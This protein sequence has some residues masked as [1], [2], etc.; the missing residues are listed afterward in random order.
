M[1]VTI[2]LLHEKFPEPEFTALQREVFAG[3]EAESSALADV[4]AAEQ[5]QAQSLTGGEPL[6]HAPIVR[7]GAYAEGDLVGW[8]YGW[9]ER[10]N[11]FY[12]ANSGV[13]AGYRRRGV[14]SAL[15]G[16]VI[17][18]A[19]GNGA[20]LVRSHHSL[21]NNPIIICKLK[22]G[23]HIVGVSTSARMGSLAEL[24]LHLSSARESLFASRVIPWAAPR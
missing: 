19:K 20:V 17:G 4:L 14:Y 6:T 11:A 18:H 21:L 5:V 2:L 24:A 8:T 22:H 10:G 1:T 12:M 7:F 3:T 16:A 9:F 13:I 15:L 23:F